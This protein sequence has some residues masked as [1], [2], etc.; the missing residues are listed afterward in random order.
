MHLRILR[1]VAPFLLASCAACT[2]T[3]DPDASSQVVGSETW[4]TPYSL[5]G[6]G[7]LIVHMRRGQVGEHS[8]G[9]YR[10]WR[11]ETAQGEPVTAWLTTTPLVDFQGEPRVRVT[12][13]GRVFAFDPGEALD[14]RDE[15]R[16]LAKGWYLVGARGPEGERF[17]DVV[18]TPDGGYRTVVERAGVQRLRAH[19]AEGALLGELELASNSLQPIGGGPE[20]VADLP[21]GAGRVIVD[22]KLAVRGRIVDYAKNPGEFVDVSRA[23]ASASG[24]FGLDEARALVSV[25]ELLMPGPWQQVWAIARRECAVVLLQQPDGG[26]TLLEP[27]DG[28]SRVLLRDATFAMAQF[29]SL[30]AEYADAELGAD[31]S[32]ILAGQKSAGAEYTLFA[33]LGGRLQGPFSA[34]TSEAATEALWAGV[35]PIVESRRAE[36]A[37][38]RAAQA[39]ARERE[40]AALQRSVDEAR[41]LLTEI[42]TRQLAYFEALQAGDMSAADRAVEAIDARLK[43]LVIPVGHEQTEALR[44]ELFLAQA[45]RLDWELRRPDG[46]IERIAHW[47]A[48]YFAQGGALYQRYCREVGLRLAAREGIPRPTY[49]ALW[50]TS[51]GF[52]QATREQLAWHNEVLERF[53]A[54]ERYRAHLAAGRFDDAH[55]MAY[56]L[57]FEGWVEHLQTQAKGRISEVELEALLRAAVQR[58]PTAEL[59]TRLEAAHHSQWLDMAAAAEREQRE[60]FRRIEEENRRAAAAAELAAR[61]ARAAYKLE[62]ARRGFIWRE[63]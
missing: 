27:Q 12:S 21:A 2:S 39:A 17:D 63:N 48:G 36:L 23:S 10:A 22:G 53:E 46:N 31:V 49:D 51:G 11:L 59:R 52:D 58:A 25:R 28:A 62:A 20:C 7:A 29:R 55:S 5:A 40:L 18:L 1:R 57:G 30:P 44:G 54:G 50:R 35:R 34:A 61:D 32:V 13:A 16:H 3:F 33:Q 56:Q 6:K 26:L 8:G 19:S 47:S 37:Q 60:R 24:V 4:P 45:Y 38:A 9:V 41:A 15:Q 42:A 14:S 43:S